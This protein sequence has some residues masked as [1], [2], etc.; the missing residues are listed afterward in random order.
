MLLL[1]FITMVYYI[2][3]LLSVMNNNVSFNNISK[4]HNKNKLI[5]AQQIEEPPINQIEYILMI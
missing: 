5:E 4:D 2:I 3:L 1:A